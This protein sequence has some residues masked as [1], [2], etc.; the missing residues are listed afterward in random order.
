MYI[1]KQ[2]LPSDIF[3]DKCNY[4]TFKCSCTKRCGCKYD[5]DL[6]EYEKKIDEWTKTAYNGNIPEYE[7][8]TD[9]GLDNSRY[10][11]QDQHNSIYLY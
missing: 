1:P 5:K 4:C 2:V 9:E 6:A 7:I 10:M 11:I 8:V 3:V